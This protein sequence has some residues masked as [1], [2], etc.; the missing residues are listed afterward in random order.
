MVKVLFVT[1]KEGVEVD[2]T[3]VV[4]NFG[5]TKHYYYENKNHKLVNSTINGQKYIYFNSFQQFL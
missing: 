1:F 2:R 5:G 4:Y 3:N